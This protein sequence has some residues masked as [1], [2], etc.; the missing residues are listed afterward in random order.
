M[1]GS[2]VKAFRGTWLLMKVI[3]SNM[4][5]LLT[6]ELLNLLLIRR[7]KFSKQSAMYAILFLFLMARIFSTLW[8]WLM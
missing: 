8:P 1:R 6:Q 4:I 2:I 3:A 7:C 5:L